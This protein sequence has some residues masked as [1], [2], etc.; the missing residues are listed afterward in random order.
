MAPCTARDGNLQ[1]GMPAVMARF[2]FKPRLN[3]AFNR[4]VVFMIASPWKKGQHEAA[5]LS[6]LHAKRR[7]QGKDNAS[8]QPL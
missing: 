4:S 8:L 2:Q 5:L 7:I 1:I 6:S 3:G